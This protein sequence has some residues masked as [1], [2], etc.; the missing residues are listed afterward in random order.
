MWEAGAAHACSCD[1]I[2]PAAGFDRAQYV[3]TGRVAK[4]E[5]HAWLVEVERVWK[6][7][8]KLDR[9]IKL[10]DAYAATGCQ[11][12]FQLGHR[13]LFFAILAKGGRDVFYHPQVCNWTRPLQSTRVP[14]QGN[15][16]GTEPAPALLWAASFA[17]PTLVLLPATAAMGGTLTALE[18]VVREARDD[19]RV[20]AGV[21]GA[22]TLGAVAGTLISTFLPLPAWGL[23][24]TLVC[25]AGANAVCALGM[26]ALGSAAVAPPR[27]LS[28]QGRSEA[29]DQN[30]V[31]GRQTHG[32]P[33]MSDVDSFR[34]DEVRRFGISNT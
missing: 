31:F 26:L 16:L 28:T 33:S 7:H 4:A 23:S 32:R 20:S 19:S 11:F 13:Y 2:P 34:L 24:G 21:Y 27:K 12:F 17:L 14:A 25:L 5:A 10:M 9:T 6:G 1:P 18:R 8:Q 29:R 22:N 30:I 15:E 3:F